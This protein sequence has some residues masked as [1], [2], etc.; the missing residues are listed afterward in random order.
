[1]TAGGLAAERESPQASCRG[2]VFHPSMPRTP[3]TSAKNES[4][5]LYTHRSSSVELTLRGWLLPHWTM[6]NHVMRLDLNGG[7]V[8][9]LYK[10]VRR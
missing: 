10:P 4:G 3:S 6:T 9:R 7:C 5:E 8:L 2:A 1:M